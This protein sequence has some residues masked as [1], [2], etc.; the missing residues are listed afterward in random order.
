MTSMDKIENFSNSW[1]AFT[2]ASR[3]ASLLSLN[4]EGMDL[5]HDFGDHW[6]HWASG[7]VMFPFPVRMASGTMM[8]FEGVKYQW[9]VNDHP[10][11]AALHGFTP[12]EEFELT[13]IAEGIQARWSYDGSKDYY[14]FPCLLTV[15]YTLDKNGLTL[16]C[17]VENMGDANLP[18][19]LGWHPYFKTNTPALNPAPVH[20]LK[21]NKLSHPGEKI[22]FERFDWTEEVDGAFFMDSIEFGD[23]SIQPLSTITQVFRPGDAPFVAIEPITGLGHPD[24]PWRTVPPGEADEVVT[25]IGLKRR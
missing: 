1:G 15:R 4:I 17:R 3:G 12:W 16:R 23:I 7:A 19:H 14:P 13:Q 18:F 11:R 24:F 2:V 9:P 6:R 10:H 5:L 20:R 8:E 21:K 25:I 22:P